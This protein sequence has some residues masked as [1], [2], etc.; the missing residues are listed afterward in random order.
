MS[1]NG[2]GNGLKNKAVT[3]GVLFAALSAVGGLA[4]LNHRGESQ[5]RAAAREALQR[6]EDRDVDGAHPKLPQRYVPR[7]EVQRLLHRIDSRLTQIDGNQTILLRRV[8][9]WPEGWLKLPKSRR[10]PRW[11]R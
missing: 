6:H 2:N 10:K 4:A 3:W 9:S 1:K 5:V 7:S 8:D 11:K